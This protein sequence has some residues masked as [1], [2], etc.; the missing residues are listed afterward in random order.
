MFR[1]VIPLFLVLILRSFATQK[2]SPS[3]LTKQN[4]CC[5]SCRD[6]RDGRDG[7]NGKDGR[8][9]RDGI[10]AGNGMKGQKGERGSPG[11]N[12]GGVIK[13]SDTAEKCTASIAG[14]VSYNTSQT[15]LQLC[16][17]SVWLPVLTVEKGYTADRPGRHCLDI[18]NSGKIKL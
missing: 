12:A 5:N 9:G 1:L 15:S 14:T 3:N 18:L 8:D 13:F 16:D 10:N 7:Q 17:G 6:G 11:N 2:T 4:H